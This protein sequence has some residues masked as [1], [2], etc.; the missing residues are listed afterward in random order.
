MRQAYQN[1]LQTSKTIGVVWNPYATHVVFDVR[2]PL[3]EGSHPLIIDSPHRQDSITEGSSSI[4]EGIAEG[5]ARDD[6][7]E[8]IHQ[9]PDHPCCGIARIVPAARLSQMQM[10]AQ[11]WKRHGNQFDTRILVCQ[12][13]CPSCRISG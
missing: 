11:E 3:L 8:M 4:A 6:I 7:I 2:F 1:E 12:H 5:H 9:R 13:Q 10:V